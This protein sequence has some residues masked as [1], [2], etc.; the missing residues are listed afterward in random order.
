[1]LLIQNLIEKGDENHEK[2]ISGPR[3]ETG[4]SQIR[5]IYIFR[6][7]LLQTYFHKW[8]IGDLSTAMLRN[9]YQMFECSRVSDILLYG[10]RI[11]IQISINSVSIAMFT[12]WTTCLCKI[13]GLI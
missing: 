3:L 9:A 12:E 6:N 13:N 4:T 1:M 8:R 2:S 5:S 7:I 11:V 10:H